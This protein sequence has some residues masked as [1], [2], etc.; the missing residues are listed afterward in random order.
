MTNNKKS[1]VACFYRIV[2]AEPGHPFAGLYAVEKVFFNGDK[3]LKKEIVHEW[4]MRI[5]SEA[6][7]ARLGGGDAYE[8]FK[9]DHEIEALEASLDSKTQP[10][11]A[12][13]EE[14]MKE[15][16]AR[17]LNKEMR[18]KEGK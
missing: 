2:K 14:D 11:E 16:T 7:L 10:V 3:F 1:K 12:R 9:L 15:M 13:T 17:K 6:T 8:S 4:D 5:L 18:L